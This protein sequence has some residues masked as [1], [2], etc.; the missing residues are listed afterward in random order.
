M[1]FGRARRNRGCQFVA[2]STAKK[3][4]W[5]KRRLSVFAVASSTDTLDAAPAAAL[6]A[7]LGVLAHEPVLDAFA[8]KLA[9]RLPVA[10]VEAAEGYLSVEDAARYLACKPQRIYD[11]RS[12]GRLRCSRTEVAC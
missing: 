7:L 3:P 2:S 6:A 5:R 9:D 8:R 4:V 12:Q 11:L 1:D 10:E